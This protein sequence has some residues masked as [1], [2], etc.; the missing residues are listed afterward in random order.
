[1]ALK[2][3]SLS[4]SAIEWHYLSVGLE[5]NV[6]TSALAAQRPG[7]TLFFLFEAFS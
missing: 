1:M 5:P 6:S 3:R 2:P 7:T 4:L